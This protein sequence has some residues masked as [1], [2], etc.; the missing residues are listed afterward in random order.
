ML[1][2]SQRSRR[3]F[4]S[5]AARLNVSMPNNPALLWRRDPRD[6]SSIRAEVA[7]A[8]RYELVAF[9]LA[10]AHGQPQHSAGK[11]SAVRVTPRD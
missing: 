9:Q 4:F 11:S 8:G 2:G 10:A 7:Y 3:V 1:A 6:T 5:A